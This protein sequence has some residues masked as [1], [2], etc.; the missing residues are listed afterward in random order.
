MSAS[1]GLKFE[2]RLERPVSRFTSKQGSNAPLRN[3]LE[4]I[5]NRN[6]LGYGNFQNEPQG[7]QP[8][9]QQFQQQQQRRLFRVPSRNEG[10][11]DPVEKMYPADPPQEFV[12]FSFTP[13][14]DIDFDD[15]IELEPLVIRGETKWF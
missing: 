13:S 2:S 1:A 3:P 5:S 4:N 11:Y 7:R 6:P 8:M 14:N 10:P 15:Q 12:G 9:H